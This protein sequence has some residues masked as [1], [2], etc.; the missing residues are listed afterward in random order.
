MDPEPSA[1]VAPVAGQA[2]GDTAPAVDTP[3]LLLG[4][5]SD[6]SLGS[7]GAVGLSYEELAGHHA[8][9]RALRKPELVAECHRV[10]V[11]GN[12][13]V[14]KATLQSRLLA[15]YRAQVRSSAL[16]G[17]AGGSMGADDARESSRP[18]TAGGLRRGFF[19]PEPLRRR[20]D[21]NVRPPS[22]PAAANAEDAAA[23]D[24]QLR[25]DFAVP[26]PQTS[27]RPSSPLEPEVKHPR[28]AAA[29]FHPA[30]RRPSPPPS[31]DIGLPLDALT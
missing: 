31:H 7:P 1:S 29:S 26:S 10:G 27:P 11:A 3:P 12:V 25:P 19:A 24:A 4:A 2:E 22:T 16:D 14:A 13:N 18:G 17:D 6:M 30:G 15:Y 21:G 28:V 9:V 23:D 20:S 5:H 8:R